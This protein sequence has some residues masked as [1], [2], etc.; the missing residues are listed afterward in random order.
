MVAVRL[1][2]LPSARR[3]TSSRSLEER[4]FSREARGPAD[5][6]LA[7]GEAS[8]LKRSVAF[9]FSARDWMTENGGAAGGGRGGNLDSPNPD[10]ARQSLSIRCNGTAI[11][12]RDL[13]TIQS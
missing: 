3:I 7:D 10:F 9:R 12:Y 5:S 4:A 11:Q 1:L 2:L 13:L 8:M 6:R